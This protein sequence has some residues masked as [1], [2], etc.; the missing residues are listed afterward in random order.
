MNTSRGKALI[1]GDAAYMYAGLAK[2][3]PAKFAEIV[4]LG[5]V[6]GKQVDL[7]DPEI[8]E[9]IARVWGSRYGGYFGPSVLNPGEEMGFEN[10]R[11]A[12][13]ILRAEDNVKSV[14]CTHQRK[15]TT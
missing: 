8:R 1:F 3:F 11:R 10:T 9:T 7:Q 15:G 6:A 14:V 13:H 2:R 4:G 5:G 12:W